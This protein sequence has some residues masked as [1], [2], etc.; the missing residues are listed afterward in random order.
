LP[1]L[2]ALGEGGGLTAKKKV[3]CLAMLSGGLD[4]IMALK[5]MQ[6][7]GIEVHALHFPPPLS[8]EKHED[9]IAAKVAK[10][11]KVPIKFMERGEDFLDLVK[12]PK[13]GYGS[14]VNPCIDCRIY[15]LKKARKFMEEIGASFI[16]TGELLDQ[17]PMSQHRKA[18]DVVEEESGL[19]G[20]LLRPLCA[21][22]L[23]PTEAEKEGLVDREKLLGLKGR[24]RLKQ[25]EFVKE[26]G[27]KEFLAPAGGCLL[28]EKEFAAK[29]YDLLEH[30]KKVFMRD[31]RLLK[32]G[33]HFR[34]GKN[35]FIV[36]R[37][38]E[39]NERLKEL[40]REED[41]MFEAEGY[42][43][44][45]TLLQGPKTEEAVKL[46]ASLTVRYSDC[47]EKECEV[48][49][50]QEKLNKSKMFGPVDEETVQKLMVKAKKKK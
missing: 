40:K 18:L 17:R 4:S 25:M 43:S 1:G 3:K 19:K 50:G 2:Q 21:K 39:E 42:G 8:D 5:M 36:G 41:V 31:L 7:Q 47:D 33:R 29:V 24:R 26:S 45:I 23:P 14:A 10:K 27:V 30:E 16:V 11:F 9:C 32:F 13:H 48:K 15:M 28:T 12:D 20:K 38:K 35:K 6:D 37:N 49:F 44:P 22:N 46:A 34:K